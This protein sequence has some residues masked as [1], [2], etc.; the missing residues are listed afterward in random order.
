DTTSTEPTSHA[1][2]ITNVFREDE[3]EES[4]ALDLSLKNAPEHEGSCFRVPKIIE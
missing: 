2:R 4:I 1:I 3:V